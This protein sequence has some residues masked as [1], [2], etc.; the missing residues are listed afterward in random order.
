MVHVVYAYMLLT[1]LTTDARHTL[2]EPYGANGSHAWCTWK[3]YNSKFVH[4]ISAVWIISGTC[5]YKLEYT[6]KLKLLLSV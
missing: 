6:E 2:D 1:I 5:M 3:C 4:F